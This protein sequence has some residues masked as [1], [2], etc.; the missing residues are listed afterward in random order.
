MAEE[1]DQPEEAEETEAVEAAEGSEETEEV[2]E[3]RDEQ[4]RLVI[5]PPPIEE[6]A[7]ECEPCKSGAPGW[8]ATF[9]DMATLLMAFFVLILSFADTELPKFDQINGSLKMAF[10]IKKIVPTVRIPSGRSLLV[11]EFTPAEAEPTVINQKRQL[12]ENPSAEYVQKKTGEQPN[13]FDTQAAYLNVENALAEEIESGQ[14]RVKVEDQKVVVELLS[15]GSTGGSG[16]AQSGAK[17]SGQVNQMTIDVATKIAQIQATVN[18]EVQLFETPVDS[19]GRATEGNK[20]SGPGSGSQG[21]GDQTQDRLEQIKADLSNEISQGLAEVERVG[22]EIVIRLANQGSFVSGSADLQSGFMP[23]LRKVGGTVF[24]G[25]GSVR[26]EGHTDN[27]PVAFSDRFIS[28]WDLSAARAASVASFFSESVGVDMGR[29]KVAGFAD[30]KPQ[31]TNDT[32]VG[33]ATNRRIE[34][35]V[36]GG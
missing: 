30:T 32:P 22:D 21:D 11:E 17:P 10:G 26:V 12:A 31:S 34:I 9:A 13:E 15:D 7:E 6:K 2:E 16:G 25:K 23:L 18:S 20:N 4:G 33:R 27:V 8:M 3:V 35:I 24:D 19:A 28:N 36:G 29:M 14:V 5:Q 1:G